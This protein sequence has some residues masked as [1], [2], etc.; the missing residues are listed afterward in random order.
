MGSAAPV[1]L[2]SDH[3]AGAFFVAAGVAVL[4]LSGDLPVG[5]LAAPGAGMMPQLVTALMI[6]FG[7]LLILRGADSAPFATIEWGDFRHAAPVL[8]ITAVAVFFYERLGFIVDTTLLML[9]LLVAVERRRVV[10]AGVFSLAV[11]LGTYFLFTV[12]LKTPL[13]KGV[14]GFLL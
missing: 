6:F 2:R 14:L 5:R 12:A 13:E 10:P 7:F 9:V 3:I 1:R 11:S 4:A 8:A